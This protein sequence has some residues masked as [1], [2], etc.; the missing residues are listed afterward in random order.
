MTSAAQ[1]AARFAA[2]FRK[3]LSQHKWPLLGAAA[4]V[5]ALAGQ[6]WAQVESSS[7]STSF[8]AVV[9]R[10]VLLSAPALALLL[11]HLLVVREYQT[12]TQLFLE[13][14]PMKRW[15]GVL[16]RYGFGL[17]ALL[18]LLLSTAGVLLLLANEAE[19]RFAAVLSARTAGYAFVLWSAAFLLGT[20]GRLRWLVYGS[21]PVTFVVTTQS[22]F[23]WWHF[24][25][26]QLVDA[27]AFGEDRATFPVE[28]LLHSL[29]VGTGLTAAGLLLSLLHEGSM[30]EVMARRASTKEKLGF[31][32]VLA[33]QGPAIAFANRAQYREPFAFVGGAVATSAEHDAQV[34][35]GLDAVEP[36]GRLLLSQLEGLASR[37]KA[38]FGV[39]PP[40]L[41]VSHNASLEG[42][43]IRS[44][45]G[46]LGAGA[47]LEA[48]LGHSGLASDELLGDLAHGAFMVLSEGRAA[49]EPNHWFL[50]GFSRYWG[51][52]PEPVGRDEHWLRV[53]TAA[54]RA[55]ITSREILAWERTLER[56]GDEA[57]TSLGF[58]LVEVLE[59]RHG[60]ALTVGLARTLLAQ[61]T[62]R[63]GFDWLT[64]RGRTLPQLLEARSGESWEAFVAAFSVQLE[65][66]ARRL[67]PQLPGL[68][69]A[70]AQLASQPS[71]LGRDLVYSLKG[72]APETTRECWLRHTGLGPYDVLVS[73]ADLTPD[74]FEWPAGEEHVEGRLQGR[75][76]PGQRAL[77]VID[78]REAEG[79]D[80]VR[81]IATRL[82]GA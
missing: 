64:Q 8:V 14:L 65:R 32:L 27:L 24:G 52:G 18:L 23:E 79:A 57:A 81:L 47:L 55:P 13:A 46:G 36:R 2:L 63:N 34:M 71:E 77:A 72:P 62:V 10:T 54:Q 28:A 44:V 45:S 31:W 37:L 56:L 15:Q 82:G 74:A 70:S 7:K 51:P 35:Y 60:R 29:A 22:G 73:N 9:R 66:E 30:A 59:A 3:E 53:A 21:L 20:L 39:Q 69:H 80:I 26:F 75:Y 41:R 68:A 42:A 38:E 58:A 6:Q 4:L 11:G 78:C 25:P 48:N 12:K 40:A 19:P 50:D 76:Q 1:L 61:P 5:A 16:A 17:A 33:A 49:F 43:E 67:S